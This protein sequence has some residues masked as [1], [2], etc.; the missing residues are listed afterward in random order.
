M[1]PTE[2]GKECLGGSGLWCCDFAFRARKRRRAVSAGFIPITGGH[3]LGKKMKVVIRQGGF[4]R[5]I[6]VGDG[7][8]IRS[9]WCEDREDLAGEALGAVFPGPLPVY[10]GT[11]GGVSG[12][13]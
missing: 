8:T 12:I 5:K 10:D 11:L 6:V 9:S 2:N 4:T 1:P 3:T 7:E 13:E